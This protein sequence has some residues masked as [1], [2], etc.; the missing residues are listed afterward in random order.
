MRGE[1]GRR[2]KSDRKC[3]VR[4]PNAAVW[5][6][7]ERATAASTSGP[8]HSLLKSQ[9]QIKKKKRKKEKEGKKERER[10]RKKESM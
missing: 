9:K 2:E 10:E 5:G 7:V 1:W 3:Q 8:R 4:S 6:V